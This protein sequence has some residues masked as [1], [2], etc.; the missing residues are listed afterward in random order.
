MPSA[1]TSGVIATTTVDTVTLT[2]ELQN[3]T[4]SRCNAENLNV[5][6]ILLREGG[7][8]RMR[9]PYILGST[10]VTFEGL[11]SGSTY[12]YHVNITE[13][14]YTLSSYSGIA[15]TSEHKVMLL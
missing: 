2:I 14:E 4:G 7:P 3:I 9:S 1:S 5:I 8:I 12:N 13:N 10:E 6:F 11:S 15:T